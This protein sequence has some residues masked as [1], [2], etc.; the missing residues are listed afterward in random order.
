MA[1]NKKFELRNQYFTTFLMGNPS[2][3]TKTTS[4]LILINTTYLDLH[5]CASGRFSIVFL[6]EYDRRLM[7]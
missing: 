1:N 7:A 3:K 5:Y 4:E 2:S 6:N